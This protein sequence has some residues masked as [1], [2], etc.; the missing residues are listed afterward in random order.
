MTAQATCLVAAPR[1]SQPPKNSPISPSSGLWVRCNA[2]C[3]AHKPRFPM[4]FE[5]T[6]TGMRMSAPDAAARGNHLTDKATAS[7]AN[8]ACL[9][10]TMAS[11]PVARDPLMSRQ[12]DAALAVAEASHATTLTPMT[13]SMNRVRSQPTR[14]D[15]AT[16]AIWTSRASFRRGTPRAKS[17]RMTR[18]DATVARSA[19]ARWMRAPR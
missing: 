16:G 2:A 10:T 9:A 13:A 6:M 11:A 18:H 5:M 1:N 17:L 19:I 7:A 15:Q 12:R 4:T 3:S 8:A 14:P